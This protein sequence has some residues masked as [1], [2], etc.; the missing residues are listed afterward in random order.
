MA[1]N[2]TQ[3]VPEHD[4]Q[5]S[6]AVQLIKLLFHHLSEQRYAKCQSCL[7]VQLMTSSQKKNTYTGQETLLFSAECMQS[8]LM[9]I[10]SPSQPKKNLAGRSPLCRCICDTFSPWD[11]TGSKAGWGKWRS[12]WGGHEN[13]G[14]GGSSRRGKG[15]HH[16][17]EASQLTSELKHVRRHSLRTFSYFSTP[18]CRRQA[19]EKGEGS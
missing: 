8:S 12:D 11:V 4:W 9:R 2:F 14:S 13:C 16:P 17:P 1:N 10:P 7:L 19:G 5:A 3:S 6:Q 18:S 15:K